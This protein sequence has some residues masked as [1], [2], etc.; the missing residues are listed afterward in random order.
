MHYNQIIGKLIKSFVNTYLFR[1]L[2]P[3]PKL[4][5]QWHKEEGAGSKKV[6]SDEEAGSREQE[7]GAGSRSREQGAE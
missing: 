4:E 2:I 3:A 5:K 1:W 7:Q 6:N